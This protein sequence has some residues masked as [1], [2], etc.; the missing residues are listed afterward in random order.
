LHNLVESQL[1]KATSHAGGTMKYKL[2]S[3]I[4]ALINSKT[5]TSVTTVLQ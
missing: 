3:V 1:V 4:K 2:T 5:T